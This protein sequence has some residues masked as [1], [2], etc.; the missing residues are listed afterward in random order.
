M[1]PPY[2]CQIVRRDQGEAVEASLK[3]DFDNQLTPIYLQVGMIENLS[4]RATLSGAELQ[5]GDVVCFTIA[6]SEKE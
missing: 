6:L 4:P 5:T 1:G 2:A 3:P